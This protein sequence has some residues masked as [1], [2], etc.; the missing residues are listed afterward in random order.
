MRRTF[1]PERASVDWWPSQYKG[2]EDVVMMQQCEKEFIVEA[3]RI[4]R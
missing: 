3:V 2:D 4:E 1:A